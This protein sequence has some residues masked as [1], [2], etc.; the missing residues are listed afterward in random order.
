MMINYGRKKPKFAKKKKFDGK[1]VL[2]IIVIVLL[3]LCLVAVATYFTL[4]YFGKKNLENSQLPVMDMR[5]ENDQSDYELVDA[6]TVRYKGKTYIFNENIK[7][8]LFLGVD[9]TDDANKTGTRIRH[10]AD[11]IVLCSIDEKSQK[12]R[13]INISRETM[14]DVQMFTANGDYVGMQKQ[15]IALSY[16]YLDGKEKSSQNT[17]QAVSDLFYGL[18][19]HAYCT[20]MINAVQPINDA[21]GGVDVVVPI[22]MRNVNSRFVKGN[23]V[24]LQGNMV[25]Q[26][27][28][29]R[30]SLS[31]STNDARI[32]RHKIYVKSFIPA[33][34]K[35]TRKDILLPLEL[36]N[37]LRDYIVTDISP[38]KIVHLTKQAL[39]LDIDDNMINLPGKSV[40]GE[41][42]MEKHLDEKA[43][44]ELVLDNFYT[45]EAPAEPQE[46]I[47]SN[48]QTKE[49]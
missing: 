3:S 13:L 16:S 20:L 42:F 49:K 46:E 18:P 15:Q 8:I 26:F 40:K 23:K 14:A 36:Y 29:S 21:I 30:S 12:V 37:M 32:E 17:V 1:K 28:R 10:Q 48:T 19:I 7:N 27:L 25:M 6:K 47:T 38:D 9:S 41:I 39:K 11:V 31:D 35:K 24:H 4:D 22:D 34:I 43:F 45:V 33:A 2:L 44:Y 5:G